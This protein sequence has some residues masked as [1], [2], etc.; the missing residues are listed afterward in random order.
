MNI[1]QKQQVFSKNIAYLIFYADSIGIQ[2]T[3]GDAYRSIEQQQ[4]YFNEG[5]SKTMDSQHRKRL[6][7]DFNF[8]VNG[9]LTYDIDKIKP[10]GDYWEKLHPDNNWGG[11]WKFIDVP[12]FE[13][14]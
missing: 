10:L 3:F 6:A 8:F 1:S 13:M 9:E 14:K 12:H 4:I 5:K 7:V 2:L 11:N